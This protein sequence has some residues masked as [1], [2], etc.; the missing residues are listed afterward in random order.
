[1][2]RPQVPVW[3]EIICETCATPS[4]GQFIKY[5]KV[6]KLEIMDRAAMAGYIFKHDTAFC[7][8]RCLG[9]YESR[10]H[11]GAA[12]VIRQPAKVVPA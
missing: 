12:A 10:L 3:C 9:L 1:M 5:A 4:P 11:A 6:P 8:H 2:A 7:S